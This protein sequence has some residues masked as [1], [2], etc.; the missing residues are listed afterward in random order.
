MITGIKESKALT[1]HISCEFKC[2]FDGEKCNSYH[3]LNNNKCWCECK[4]FHI[5]E[6]EIWNPTT[7]NCENGKYLAS[8]MDDS[9]DSD[10]SKLF[11]QILMKWK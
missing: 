5:C 3:W 8:I 2:R 1:K 6:K 11:Q 7:C 10:D 9:F 4:K